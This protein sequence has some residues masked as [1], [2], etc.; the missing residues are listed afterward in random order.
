MPRISLIGSTEHYGK[1]LCYI[2]L[3]VVLESNIADV[4]CQG[5]LTPTVGGRSTPTFDDPSATN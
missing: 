1:I 2:M 4:W 3:T 5:R